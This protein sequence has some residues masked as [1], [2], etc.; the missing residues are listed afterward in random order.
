MKR[1]HYFALPLFFLFSKNLDA[2]C[3]KDIQSLI[4]MPA[5][6]FFVGSIDFENTECFDIISFQDW[7]YTWLI[8]SA[9]DGELIAQYDGVAFQHTFKKFGGYQFCLEID[10]DGDPTNA[11]DLV[12]CVTYTTCEVCSQDTINME[13]LNCPYG[14]GCEISLSAKIPAANDYGL[15]PV[16]KFIVTY[17]PTPQELL[18]GAESYELEFGDIDIEYDP[19]KDTINV[20]QNIKVPFRRGCY[21]PRIEMQL[22]DGAG[23]HGGDGIACTEV[24]LHSEKKFRCIAC[25]NENGECIASI[26][27]AQIS[28]EEDTCNPFY[29]CNLL[30]ENPA[31]EQDLG[32]SSIFALSPNPAYDRIQIKLPASRA[33]SRALIFTNY[34][35]Q[36]ILHANINADE[37]ERE[38]TIG[39]LPTGQYFVTL[40][41]NGLR[42][43]TTKLL[44]QK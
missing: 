37:T 2:Q 28:N 41:E 18:G 32:S 10:K 15:V 34:M 40:L 17:L 39:N 20:A 9:K 43:Q 29:Y 11:P 3:I 19:F 1:I 7:K 44:V 13:Y 16:A 26:V 25:A 24:S 33:E 6:C 36:A 30:R 4:N 21:K 27:A 42:T 31:D 23:A 35:G 22:E 38:V 8:K 14:E 12:D 5:P